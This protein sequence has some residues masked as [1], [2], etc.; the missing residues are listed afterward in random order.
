M[1]SSPTGAAAMC[2]WRTSSTR[3]RRRSP[4][5][6]RR[7]KRSPPRRAVNQG[8]K[9]GVEIDQGIFLAQTLGVEEAGLH[10]CHAMLLPRP[11]TA[12][13]LARFVA[14]GVLDLGTVKLERKGKAVLLTATNPRFL[15]AE[16]NTTL[17]LMETAVDVAIARSGE[18][19]RGDARRQG[20]A[21]EISRAATSSAAAST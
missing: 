7:R 4:A 21:S 14:D 15:N 12:E 17:D 6:P 5:L 20:R 3:R 16:D 9:E 1:R 19:D 11:E 18:R 13:H 8:D 10:L 2:G